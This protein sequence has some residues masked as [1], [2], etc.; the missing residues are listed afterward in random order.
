[1]PGYFPWFLMA[2]LIIATVSY[3]TPE[4]TAGFAFCDII[5]NFSLV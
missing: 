3:I 5:S 4:M 2:Y 1:M